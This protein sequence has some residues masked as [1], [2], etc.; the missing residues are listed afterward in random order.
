MNKI[1]SL[2]D[3]RCNICNFFVRFTL[4]RHSPYTKICY[5]S[6]QSSFAL[7]EIQEAGLKISQVFP[8]CNLTFEEIKK[9][10]AEERIE[11]LGD[12]SSM[13]IIKDKKPYMKSAGALLMLSSLKQPYGVFGKIL[14]YIVPKAL[15]D[16]LYTLFA[17]YRFI[18][19]GKTVYIDKTWV[20]KFQA[21][22]DLFLDS[23]EGFH[24][25]PL[26]QKSK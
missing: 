7:K 6:L 1:L 23:H 12:P 21:K 14:S 15:G 22:E 19:F 20:E 5:A 17:Q 13:V 9:L 3:G 16:F 4:T 10:D 2:Y 11:K 8:S 24:F 26:P 25:C 18:L